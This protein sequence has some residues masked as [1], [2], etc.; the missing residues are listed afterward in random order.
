MNQILYGAN[1]ISPI[2]L[3]VVLLFLLLAGIALWKRSI[4]MFAAW[5]KDLKDMEPLCDEELLRP[6]IS[7]A[8]YKI[9]TT[10]LSAWFSWTSA[11]VVG[12]LLAPFDATNGF[13][14][15]ITL[16]ACVSPLVV[17]I[18]SLTAPSGALK[19]EFRYLQKLFPDSLLRLDQFKKVPHQSWSDKK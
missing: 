9:Y 11:L 10:K 6:W 15:I 5:K 17:A 14:P 13:P 4:D 8:Y 16:L 18:L 1:K 19:S 3:T 2:I 7:N 12:S